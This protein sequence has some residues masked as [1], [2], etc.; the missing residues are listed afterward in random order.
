MMSD[1]SIN[2]TKLTPKGRR[3]VL[4]YMLGISIF[5]LLLYSAINVLINWPR[6]IEVSIDLPGDKD[7]SYADRSIRAWDDGPKYFIWRRETDVY[8]HAPDNF[9]SQEAVI[10]YIDRQL[11]SKGW[12]QFEYNGWFPCDSVLPESNFL[13]WGNTYRGYTQQNS[14]D[15]KSSVG[16][17]L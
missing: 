17:F 9:Y 11:V 10:E 12:H 14:N 15:I 4:L 1:S 3:S 5:C 13:E 8:K 2:E 6:Y 16:L 7:W